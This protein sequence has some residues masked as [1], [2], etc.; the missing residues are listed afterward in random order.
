VR[1]CFSSTPE[2]VTIEATEFQTSS[3]AGS[4]CASMMSWIV[5]VIR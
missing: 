2:A 3:A 4:I 1:G 5:A